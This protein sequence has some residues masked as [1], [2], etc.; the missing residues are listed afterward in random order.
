MKKN[1]W[2]LCIA[3]AICCGITALVDAVLQPSYFIKSAI[4]AVL[5]LLIPVILGSKLQFSP[6]RCLRPEKRAILTGVGFGIGV[7]AA[8][9]GGYALLSPFL[10]LSA[11]PGALKAGV[12]VTADNF[13][14]VS[15][16]IALCNSLLEEFFFR[17]FAYLT[18]KRFTSNR[19]AFCFSA[20]C[21]AVYHAA[22]MKGWFSPVLMVLTLFALFVCGLF[23]N[24]LDHKQ[25]RI[26]I[27]WL[28]HLFANLAINT[29]GM[30]LLGM[31]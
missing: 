4:K 17:G 8:V 13:L 10:D 26:W 11:I 2:I 23:F 19:F 12:G 15:L 31:F 25:E 29:I 3:V 18:L 1:A 20:V 30:K 5:F 14:Y 16:Y 6:F 9:L 21:F 27:S 28:V 7:F 22:I 24:W